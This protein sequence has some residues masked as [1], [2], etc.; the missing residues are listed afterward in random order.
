M[1]FGAGYTFFWQNGFVVY[2]SVYVGYPRLA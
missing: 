1:L 2:L